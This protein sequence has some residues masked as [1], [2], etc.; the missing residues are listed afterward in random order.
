VVGDTVLAYLKDH[1]RS[2]GLSTGDDRLSVLNAYDVEGTDTVVRRRGWPDD[3]F[4]LRHRHQ[5]ASL[6]FT[7][8]PASTSA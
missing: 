7:L 8:T 3:L 2:S 1:W 4:H 5:S 6:R